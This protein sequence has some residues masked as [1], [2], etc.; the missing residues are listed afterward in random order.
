LADID[1]DI[2]NHQL[3]KYI[4]TCW[5]NHALI[6]FMRSE[7]KPKNAILFFSFGKRTKQ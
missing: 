3:L 6:S 7:N 4:P 5:T 1:L 2:I